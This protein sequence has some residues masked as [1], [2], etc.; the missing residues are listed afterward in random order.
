[1][2]LL[3]M[4][5]TRLTYLMW[6]AFIGIYRLFVSNKFKFLQLFFHQ[7]VKYF[8]SYF[9]PEV[10]KFGFVFWVFPLQFPKMFICKWSKTDVRSSTNILFAAKAKCIYPRLNKRRWQMDNL[11]WLEKML[12]LF[13]A[14]S[15][16]FVFGVILKVAWSC[17]DIRNSLVTKSLIQLFGH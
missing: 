12:S 9:M 6:E 2:F 15:E 3:K 17:F 8:P 16:K 14:V 13:K 4:S 11:K 10:L 7:H 5:V 1:M